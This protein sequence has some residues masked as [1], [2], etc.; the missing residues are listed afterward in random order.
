MFFFTVGSWWQVLPDLRLGSNLNADL[1][2]E[3]F[4]LWQSGR[5]EDAFFRK[6][7]RPARTKGGKKKRK[8]KRC[9]ESW[10]QRNR[11]EE[12]RWKGMGSGVF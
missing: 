1:E 3:S 4:D 10:R 9:H 12:R 8:G 7:P 6:D 5:M 2:N 11:S